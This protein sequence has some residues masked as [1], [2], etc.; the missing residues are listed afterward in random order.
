MASRVLFWIATVLFS[1]PVS[2]VPAPTGR[3]LLNI[4][5]QATSLVI[6]PYY[7][8]QNEE[9][10]C[11]ILTTVVSCRIMDNVYDSAVPH[12]TQTMQR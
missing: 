3:R 7:W 8:M 12:P 4:L 6:D 11:C 9:V 1:I 10:L 2:S 5:G